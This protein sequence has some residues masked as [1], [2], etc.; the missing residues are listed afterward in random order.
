MNDEVDYPHCRNCKDIYGIALDHLKA[1]KVMDCGHS[2][3]KECLEKI[4]NENFGK[5]F[6]CP[7]CFSEIK[8]RKI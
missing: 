8:K 1:P 6:I 5:K 4:I 7:F 2:I 3:C